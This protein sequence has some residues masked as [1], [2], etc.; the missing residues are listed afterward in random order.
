MPQVGSTTARGYGSAHQKERARWAPVVAAGRATCARPE[1]RKP[2]DPREPW[3]L[4]HSD[5]R[6]HW[7]G[8]EH[9]SCNR[10]A[11]QRKATARRRLR[12]VA[13]TRIRW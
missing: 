12:N 7:T 9:R 13:V 8:P 5:D 1:C 4:G 2:I 10:R 3:D 11:G 6:T